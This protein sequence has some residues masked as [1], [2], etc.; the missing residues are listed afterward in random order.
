MIFKVV[1]F[2]P[3]VVSVL[4]VHYELST[5][6]FLHHYR[7]PSGTSR[8]PYQTFMTDMSMKQLLTYRHHSIRVSLYLDYDN[9]YT[10][11]LF[12]KTLVC[13]LRARMLKRAH[14][15]SKAPQF[16]SSCCDPTD[17]GVTPAL[18]RI[19]RPDM[20]LQEQMIPPKDCRE[21]HLPNHPVTLFVGDM[22]RYERG[23]S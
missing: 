20:Q 15:G 7:I 8:R 12:P 18:A 21:C 4:G 3:D 13:T 17:T 19:L 5:S 22:M 23:R 11:E 2:E 9:I 14:L 6:L 16:V 10:D 1:L